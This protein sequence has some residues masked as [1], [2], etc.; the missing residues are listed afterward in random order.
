MIQLYFLS[1]LCNGL[2]GYI[3]FTGSNDETVDKQPFP[4]NNPT[5][6]LVLGIISIV[7][8]VLKLL[9]PVKGFPILG[10]LIPSVAGV[11]AGAVMIF[12][13]H[14]KNTDSIS[15]NPGPLDQLCANLLHF[16]KY[17]GIGLLGIAFIHFF[18]PGTPLF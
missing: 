15:E 17:I 7:T 5:F 2:C 4:F 14:R 16:R 11:I 6:L 3:L 12:G 18:L 13:I 10:D 9:T 8:G 1:I